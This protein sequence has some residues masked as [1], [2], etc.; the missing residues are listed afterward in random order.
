MVTSGRLWCDA[1][2]LGFVEVIVYFLAWILSLKK[3]ANSLHLLGETSFR[4]IGTGGL[5]NWSLVADKIYEL[6]LFE[7]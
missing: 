3:D 7:R 5:V 6:L 4:D 2:L 1:F